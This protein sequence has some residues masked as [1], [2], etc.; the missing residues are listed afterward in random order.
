MKSIRVNYKLPPWMKEQVEIRKE[1][2]Q[3]NES[4]YIREAL[5]RQF[6]WEDRNKKE[7]II[8]LSMMSPAA[9]V[10][11]YDPETR[12]VTIVETNKSNN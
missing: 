3:G 9:I 2:T 11:G 12:M 1:R 5:L 4:K 10:T 7:I 6:E 8:N